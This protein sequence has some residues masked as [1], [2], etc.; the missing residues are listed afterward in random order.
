MPKISFWRAND[1]RSDLI[2]QMEQD[3]LFAVIRGENIEDGYQKANAV[4]KGGI[5]ILEITFTTPNADL[6]IS[7]IVEQYKDDKEI[8]IGAGTVIDELSARIAIIRGAQF[9]VAPSFN[10]KVAEICNLYSIPYIPGAMTI[11]NIEEA[12]KAGCEIVKIFPASSLGPSFVKSVRGPLPQIRI[13]AT[14]GINLN[15]IKDYL[16]AGALLVGTGSDLT[17]GNE[18]EIIKK[19]KNYVNLIK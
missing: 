10:K 8:L 17:K 4:I 19:A 1:M 2:K 18:E 14:G 7:R 6:L 13:M 9:I 5:K 16:N 15:N 3:V 12:L 11:D